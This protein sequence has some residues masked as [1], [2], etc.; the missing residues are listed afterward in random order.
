MDG[1]TERLLRED[2]HR[3]ARAQAVDDAVDEWH[4][5]SA[6]EWRSWRFIGLRAW[7]GWT[8]EEYSLWA[9]YAWMPTKRIGRLM[10]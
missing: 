2:E 3:K 4:E 5:L 10:L 8:E 1:M 9:T 7:L 6:Q